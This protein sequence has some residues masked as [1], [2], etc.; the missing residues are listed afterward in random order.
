[1]TPDA[2]QGL[3]R[4]PWTGRLWTDQ[5][6]VDNRLV[7]P[8]TIWPLLPSPLPLPL[9]GQNVGDGQPVVG[10]VDAVAELFPGIGVAVG[11]AALTPG[12]YQV[13]IVVADAK[14][15]EVDGVLVVTAGKLSNVTVYTVPDLSAPAWPDAE[16]TVHDVPA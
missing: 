16:I 8:G 9:L 1:M 11:T 14:W 13:G 3:P 12:R 10:T 4:R 6:T 7:P 2:T 5:V 15:D